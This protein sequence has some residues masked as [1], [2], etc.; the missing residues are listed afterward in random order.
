MTPARKKRLPRPEWAV[1]IERLRKNEL[2]I[3]G[4]V[5]GKALGVS[6][7]AVSRWENGDNEPPGECYAKMG[8]M[9][10]APNTRLYFWQKAG[11]DIEVLNSTAVASSR[12][13]ARKS[14][15]KRPQKT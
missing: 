3:T 1:R 4:T 13:P 8:N 6:A 2:R 11:I 10:P 14:P 9:A 7:M 15:S 5:F 12:R